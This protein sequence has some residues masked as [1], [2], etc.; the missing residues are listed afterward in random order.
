MT[1]IDS[2][3]KVMIG[4]SDFS[5]IVAMDDGY[6]FVVNS[7]SAEAATGQ[8][9]SGN[10]RVPVLGERVQLSIKCPPYIEKTRLNELVV[11]L[12]MGT[13]GQRE[14][15]ITY[16]DPLF[17]TLTRNFYCTNIGWI[18]SKLPNYPYHYGEDISFK[19]T[20]TTFVKAPITTTIVNGVAADNAEYRLKINGIEFSDV[21]SIDGF[22][23][24]IIEQ[25]L[26]SQTGLT[27]DGVF[28]IP[29]IGSRSMIEID[30]VEYLEA[31]RFKQLGKALG[32]G[33]TGER[34]HTLTYEDMIK[35]QTTQT[36]YCTE[37]SGSKVKLPNA[38]Y[39]YIKDVKFQQAMKNFF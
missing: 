2:N 37:I 39:H 29:I 6:Q 28:H 33:K 1:T 36:F 35:G 15:A 5:D 24:Q 23:G 14:V 9:T 16:D 17:G 26:E 21:I 32:F 4:G 12:K 19:L 8:D 20:S 22:K 38:P 34:S 7:F 27:L 31:D 30:C 11:A 18:K 25:S 13:K 10:F 3:Y